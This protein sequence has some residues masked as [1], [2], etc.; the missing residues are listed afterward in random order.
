MW[1]HLLFFTCILMIF[2]L[3]STC[4]IFV[5]HT[6]IVPSNYINYYHRSNLSSN[7][8]IYCFTIARFIKIL[9]LSPSQ[10]LFFGAHYQFDKTLLFLFH[11]KILS[12]TYIY[13][14]SS[15]YLIIIRL[16]WHSK[17]DLVKKEKEIEWKIEVKVPFFDII[18]IGEVYWRINPNH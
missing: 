5:I 8:H 15:L 6:K 12:L 9:V 13:L 17:E 1:L 14:W 4:E 2:F 16:W 11:L 10:L 3:S 7:S 18:G